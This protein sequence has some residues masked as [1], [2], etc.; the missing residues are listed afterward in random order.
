MLNAIT[1]IGRLVAN[2]TSKEIKTKEG[3]VNQIANFSIA[4][5]VNKDTTEFVDCT[6]SYRLAKPVMDNLVKGDKIV[7]SGTFRNQAWQTKD[8]QN[9]KTATIYVDT[10]EFVDVLKFQNE[11]PFGESYEEPKEEPKEVKQEPKEEP[12][13]VKQEPK[14]EPK[15]VKQEP[16]PK[17]QTGRRRG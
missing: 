15:E 16:Q 14:E 17:P 2:P 6:T 11:D 5:Q 12:K 3:E 7:V 9:R 8:G 13:E 10:I 1:L 4:F